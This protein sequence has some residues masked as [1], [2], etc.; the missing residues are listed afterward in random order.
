MNTMRGFLERVGAVLV[1]RRLDY[2]EHVLLTVRRDV[3]RNALL[4]GGLHAARVRA[5]PD[6]AAIED[7]EFKVFSQSGEDGIIQYLVGRVPIENDTFVEI[8]VEDYRES[9]TRFLLLHNNWRGLA[10]DNGEQNVR[11]IRDDE[12]CIWRELQAACATVT[13]ENVN[14]VLESAG[15]AGDIGLLSIDIDGNDYWVWDAVQTVSPRIVVC[16]YNALF[17]FRRAVTVPYDPAFS[18][19]KAHFSRLYFGA[20][21][22]AMCRLAEKK[23][24]VFVGTCSAGVNAF[25]VRRD[26]AGHVKART[27]AE[28]GHPSRIREARDETGRL[29]FVSGADR[30]ALIKDLQVLD[31]E[32]DRL[33]RLGDIL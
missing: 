30:S 24:Y 32:S 6:G 10:V 17:G 31:L 3:E 15:F 11:R 18:R 13:R 4:L 16:E 9:N 19:E 14:R 28:G 5:L 25:F 26:A 2:L 23:G 29:S 21:L 33:V 7:A 12:I 1:G 20:S 8:G 27:A 22:P